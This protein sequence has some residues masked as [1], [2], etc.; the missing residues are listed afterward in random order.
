MDLEHLPIA[1]RFSFDLEHLSNSV[2]CNPY[3]LLVKIGL[4][5]HH[6]NIHVCCEVNHHDW[7]YWNRFGCLIQ[8]PIDFL[9]MACLLDPHCVVTTTLIFL[10]WGGLMLLISS[11]LL[12]RNLT[13][14]SLNQGDLLLLKVF[15]T[16]LELHWHGVKSDAEDTTS[17]V[18]TTWY[19]FWV[20]QLQQLWKYG[21]IALKEA[22]NIGI[23]TRCSLLNIVPRF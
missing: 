19:R 15:V 9:N 10:R 14:W 18:E 17:L 2:S 12:V 4:V 7:S 20:V 13:S 5:N 1:I 21:L 8:G 11:M 23:Y 3:H 6:V 22:W 16:V